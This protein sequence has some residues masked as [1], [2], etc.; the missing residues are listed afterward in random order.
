MPVGEHSLNRIAPLKSEV[1]VTSTIVGEKG[2][3]ADRPRRHRTVCFV[4]S[5]FY[6]GHDFTGHFYGWLNWFSGLHGRGCRTFFSPDIKLG[7]WKNLQNGETCACECNRFFHLILI[8]KKQNHSVVFN[9]YS[10]I[11]LFLLY[12][13]KAVFQ[14]TLKF[15]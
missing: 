8:F 11:I 12:I 4:K 15:S 1:I 13:P 7:D 6:A 10:N 5:V 9:V 3:E 2:S 14:R